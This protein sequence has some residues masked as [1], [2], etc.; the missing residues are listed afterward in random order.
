MLGRGRCIVACSGCGPDFGGAEFVSTSERSW[1]EELD[2]HIYDFLLLAL[3]EERQELPRHL[4]HTQDVIA[5]LVI[6]FLPTSH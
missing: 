4:M 6:Q 2:V 5:E 1:G 3:L